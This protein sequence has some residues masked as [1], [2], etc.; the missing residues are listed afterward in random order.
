[1]SRSGPHPIRLNLG[2]GGADSLDVSQIS[3]PVR[4]LLIGAVVFLA[5]WFTVLRPKAETI[6]PTTTTPAPKTTGL[7]KA[8]AAA[9]SAAGKAVATA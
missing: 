8:V 5:A 9:K 2:R 1:M 3:P 7:G 4:I 6:E